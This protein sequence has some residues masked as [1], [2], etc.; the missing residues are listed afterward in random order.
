VSDV[1]DPIPTR[2]GEEY[3]VEVDCSGRTLT[4]AVSLHEVED[5]VCFAKKVELIKGFGRVGDR[6]RVRCPAPGTTINCM[7]PTK[8]RYCLPRVRRWVQENCPGV[9]Y[10]D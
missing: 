10:V 5:A 8:N 6:H 1:S 3:T 7:P 2:T 9:H 4:Y